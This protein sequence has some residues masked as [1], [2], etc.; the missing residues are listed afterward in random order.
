MATK[1]DEAAKK[2]TK[3]KTAPL[4]LAAAAATKAKGTAAASVGTAASAPA[5]GSAS[6]TLG[7]PKV[8]PHLTGINTVV[9]IY[10]KDAMF[11]HRDA[12]GESI[13]VLIEKAV[14]KYLDIPLGGDE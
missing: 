1:K 5:S 12:T 2:P 11:A 4:P 7:R 3:P 6:K 14:A 10:I 13:G 9:P 8:R